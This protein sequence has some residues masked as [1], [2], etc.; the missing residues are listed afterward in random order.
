LQRLKSRSEAFSINAKGH[1]SHLVGLDPALNEG[2]PVEFGRNP[3]LIHP[4][5]SLN[6]GPV[7][8]G[9]F[10]HCQTDVVAAG[11]TLKSR[12]DHALEHGPAR[13]CRSQ[14]KRVKDLALLC[15]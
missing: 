1:Y 9:G 4:I 5:T 15:R 2:L 10:N 11:E 6:P 14:S 8:T 3:N 7:Q 13:I 12:G